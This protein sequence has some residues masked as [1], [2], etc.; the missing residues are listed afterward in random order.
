M[1]AYTQAGLPSGKRLRVNESINWVSQNNHL[2]EQAALSTNLDS[3][4]HKHILSRATIFLGGSRLQVAQ[5]G[6]SNIRRI[7]AYPVVG[8]A[9]TQPIQACLYSFFSASSGKYTS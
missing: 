9:R 4:L 8:S 3:N 2:P 1:Y 6:V 5:V 7:G